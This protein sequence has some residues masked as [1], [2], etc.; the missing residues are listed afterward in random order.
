MV[1]SAGRHETDR[2]RFI[3][4]SDPLQQVQHASSLNS[5]PSHRHKLQQ[6]LV[7]QECKL[8]TVGQLT[9]PPAR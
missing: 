1:L 7:H 9:R 3:I 2:W 5:A 8:A 4:C 6:V